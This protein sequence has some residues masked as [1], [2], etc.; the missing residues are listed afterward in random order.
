MKKIII[1][2]AFNL[3]FIGCSYSKHLADAHK[4]LVEARNS[5]MVKKY[6]NVKLDDAEMAYSKAKGSTQPD[7][8]YMAKRRAEIALAFAQAKK[9][10][11][12]WL[13]AKNECE[14]NLLEQKKAKEGEI[15]RL[16]AELA[17]KDR[18]LK[19]KE[20]EWKR[21]QAELMEAIKGLG[22]VKKEE[23]GLVLYISDILFDF[24][25]SSL[26]AASVDGLTKIAG[27]LANYPNYSIKIEGH[28]DWIG[29]DRYNMKLSERRAKSVYSFFVN[30]GIASGRLTMQGFG[31]S[32]PIADN[33]TD[34]GRQRNRRVEII[35]NQQQ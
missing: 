35:V 1:L 16:K 23:R 31:E 13:A 6:A 32:K 5:Q 30:N 22:E 34:A 19:E 3:I 8:I 2:L 27:A 4:K 24:N 26:R 11:E 28:T 29:S 20:E 12:A 25:K 10:E 33:K 7:D 9:Q 21:A 15:D 14:G 17:E 18:L